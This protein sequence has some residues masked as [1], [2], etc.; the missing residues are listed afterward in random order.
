MK[1]KNSL[2]AIIALFILSCTKEK[3]IIESES[4]AIDRTF[5]IDPNIKKDTAFKFLNLLPETYSYLDDVIIDAK[6]SSNVH[7]NYD[8]D[9]VSTEHYYSVYNNVKV[10]KVNNDSLIISIGTA[11]GYTGYGLNLVLQNNSYS[12][13]YYRFLDMLSYDD[14]EPQHKTLYQNLILNKSKYHLND[15]L[16]GFISFKS[17]YINERGDTLYVSAKGHFRGKVGKREF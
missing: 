13:K 12:S 10:F 8:K 9:A 3:K 6:K 1:K 15:S 7:F 17:R 4:L 16:Y 2:I 5:K 11:D 14:K